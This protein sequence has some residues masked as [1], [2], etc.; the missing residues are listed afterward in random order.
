M[1]DKTRSGIEFTTR[2]AKAAPRP[3]PGDRDLPFRMLILGDFSGRRTRGELGHG[4]RTPLRVDLDNFETVLGKLAP[5][6]DLEFDAGGRVPVT[7][8]TMEDFTPDRLFERLAVFEMLRTLRVKLGDPASFA[9]AADLLGRTA[10]RSVAEMTG[11]QSGADSIEGLLERPAVSVAKACTAGLVDSLVRQ[12]VDPHVVRDADPRQA[13]MIAALEA[14]IAGLMNSILHHPA[15]QAV[16]ASWRGLDLLIHSLDLDE[17]LALYVLD[18]TREE[19]EEQLASS[20]EASGS[21]L[22]RIVA[23]PAGGAPWSVLVGDYVFETNEPDC[24]LLERLGILAAKAGAPFLATMNPAL[25]VTPRTGRSTDDS[26][27]WG[28]LRAS[29]VAASIGLALP[30]VLL[31]L[32]YGERKEPV[33]SFAFE[34][35]EGA[36]HHDSCLWGSAAM[37]CAALLGQSFRE[38]EG[39]YF[40]PGD[41][42]SFGGLPVDTYKDDG[43][44][45]QTPCGEHWLSEAQIDSLIRDGLIPLVSRRGRDEVRV[46]RFQSIASPVHPLA[47][48]WR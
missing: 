10:S 21:D 30:R 27:A 8:E 24:L 6:V 39:W 9:E 43:E 20:P 12:A 46:A 47:G 25:F 37:V 17:Q 44:I 40:E 38:A 15:F 3:R 11:G 19:L 45:V 41:V 2:F 29:P 28:A 23:E 13:G 48:R 5:T 7:I 26:K 16:E 4:L 35:N 18:A 33:S 34:E 36:P 14:D 31:R 22:Y 1:T 32:P 42:C